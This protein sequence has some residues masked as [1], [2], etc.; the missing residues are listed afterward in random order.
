M[1]F[2]GGHYS[3]DFTVEPHQRAIE[4]AWR[5]DICGKDIG[6]VLRK[7]YGTAWVICVVSHEALSIRMAP[8]DTQRPLVIESNEQTGR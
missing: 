1:F 6:R 8:I 5:Q 4:V 3:T 7:H 2:G